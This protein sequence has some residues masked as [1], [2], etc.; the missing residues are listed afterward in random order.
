VT[1]RASKAFRKIKKLLKMQVILG[2]DFPSASE[3]SLKSRHPATLTALSIGKSA[4]NNSAD[5]V[6]NSLRLLR[7]PAFVRLR[8]I[9][10]KSANFTLS[11]TARPRVFSQCRQTFSVN[12]SSSQASSQTQPVPV[13]YRS[14]TAPGGYC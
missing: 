11:V 1:K 4:F 10:S 14:M 12:G 3:E 8:E 6:S 9:A 2:Y 5:R 13:A 7:E